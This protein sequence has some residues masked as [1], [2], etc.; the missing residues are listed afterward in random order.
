[1]NSHLAMKSL[2]YKPTIQDATMLHGIRSAFMQQ[3]CKKIEHVQF[4]CN[5]VSSHN[6]H[7]R[8]NFVAGIDVTFSPR[9]CIIVI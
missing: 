8:C 6:Q 3:C 9:K 7:T 1:M 5:K 4:P 2:H